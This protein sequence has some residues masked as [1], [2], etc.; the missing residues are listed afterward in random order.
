MYDLI[1]KNGWVIDG[2]GGPPFRADVAVKGTNIS[3][4]GR[5]DA[6]PASKVLDVAGH[7]IVPGFIDAHVHGDL[8]LLADPIALP[9]LRQGVTTYIIGQDGSSF[10]PASPATL[11]YMLRYT[12]GFNGNPSGLDKPWRTVDE[13]LSRFDGASAINVAYLIPNG[14]VRMEVMG[15]D[16]RPATEDELRAMKRLVREGMDAGAVGLSTGLDYIPSLY[17]DAREISALCAAIAPVNGVYVTHMRGYGAN[18]PAG[19]RE[20]YEIV[21]NSGAA[22]HISHYNGPAEV[23][24]PLIDQGRALGFD[25]TFDTYPYLAGSTILGMTALPSWVQQGGIEATLERLDDPAVRARL[26]SEWF[27]GPLHYP[28]DSTRIAMTGHPSWQWA[29]GHTVTE[30][31]RQAGLTPGEFVRQILLACEMAVGVVGFGGDRTEED[32]RAILRHSAHMAGSDGIFSGGYPHPRG[33]GAF[34]RYLARHTRELGDYTWA[35]AVTHLSS[36][37]AR[38]F[39][40]A[41]RGLI[42]PGFAADLAVIDP[43]ALVD[44]STYAAGRMLAEGVAHVVVNGV[45]VLQDGE[46]TGATPGR[47]LRRS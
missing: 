17:A 19:M 7:Y 23:L 34:A 24:L 32:V 21:R 18:A 15:L 6:A 31:A 4:L 16:P 33:W 1:L 42:R 13:Y 39:R 47:A 20:V 40:L 5:L 14:N 28:L 29:E 10:A 11:Q 2:C 3:D 26:H 27:T 12:A 36:H 43:N 30:A 8:T 22:A 37:A 25:L 45:L 46:A 41:D 38:R 35:E 44:R 9:A